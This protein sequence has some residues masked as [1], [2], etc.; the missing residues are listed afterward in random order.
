MP[1][2]ATTAQCARR[3]EIPPRPERPLNI[4]KFLKNTLGKELT[5]LSFPVE[6]NEPL[7]MLQRVLESLEFSW[8]LDRAAQET[9]VELQAAI[10]GLYHAASFM[11]ISDRIKKPFNPLLGETFELDLWNEP[12]GYRAIVE[13]VE[14]HPPVT[15]LNVE[16][17]NGWRLQTTIAAT[18]M[19]KLS[20]MAVDIKSAGGTTLTFAKTNRTFSLIRPATS[21][22]LLTKSPTLTV[23]GQSSVSLLE[24][25]TT[26]TVMQ[27]QQS[28]TLSSSTTVP[29]STSSS[30][31]SSIPMVSMNFGSPKSGL[32]SSGNKYALSGRT[33]GGK[34]ELKSDNCGDYG[35]IVDANTGATLMDWKRDRL[36]GEATR[37]NSSHLFAHFQIFLNQPTQ[38]NIC[39]TDT[40]L[41]PDQRLM[42]MAK[43]DDSESVKSHLETKQRT[44]RSQKKPLTEMWFTRNPENPERREGQLLPEWVLSRDYYSMKANGWQKSNEVNV[45]FEARGR[46]LYGFLEEV[47]EYP[48]GTQ[49]NANVN[50]NDSPDNRVEANSGRKSSGPISSQSVESYTKSCVSLTDD[51]SLELFESIQRYYADNAHTPK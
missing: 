27:M 42:E 12:E 37:K 16:S 41:R 26:P 38:S 19:F 40:R 36:P 33:T 51:H 45:D 48:E 3:T 9:D 21:L 4:I 28:S 43:Y 32:F 1:Q 5:R 24:G 15:A 25:Y 50:N 8:L 22:T 7:S 18:S 44:R 49:I 11:R 46:A 14:H 35:E 47:E 34:Y 10:L 30:R 29:S 20:K 2:T 17:R 13:Q 31:V 6:F 23:Q 39:P